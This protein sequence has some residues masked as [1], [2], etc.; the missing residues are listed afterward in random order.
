MKNLYILNADFE[1]FQPIFPK[2]CWSNLCVDT[3]KTL[4]TNF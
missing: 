4:P 2:T 1:G 3:D